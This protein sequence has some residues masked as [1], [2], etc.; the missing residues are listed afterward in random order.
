MRNVGD[1]IA[2]QFFGLGRFQHELAEVGGQLVDRGSQPA[3]LIGAVD[4]HPRAVF[5]LGDCA[6]GILHRP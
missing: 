1:E 6:G 2:A 4:L 3:D 5:A